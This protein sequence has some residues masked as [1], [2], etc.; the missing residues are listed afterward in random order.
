MGLDHELVV[1]PFPPRVH[2]KEYLGT[3][4]LGTVP[5]LIDAEVR[6]TESPA[7]CHYL[8]ERYGPTPLRVPPED[9]EYPFYLNWL[10]FSDAT[11]TFPQTLVLR[12]TRLEPEERRV[13]QVVEDYRRWFLGRL[14]AVEAAVETRQF[15]CRGR[16]T[17]ADICIG[18]ALHLACS[19]GI[20]EFGPNTRRY[21]EGLQEIPSYQAV[22]ER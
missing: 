9:E 4:R 17:I 15:L 5:Y 8:V 20:D 3:N 14:R 21:W 18:Y 1:L 11:L 7:I 16:F 2:Q 6:M 22:K 10:Y 12:Y 19:L 13:P